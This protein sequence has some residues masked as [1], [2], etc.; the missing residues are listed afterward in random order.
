MKFVW[1]F[2]KLLIDSSLSF[3][4]INSTID[5]SNPFSTSLFPFSFSVVFA[6]IAG[7]GTDTTSVAKIEVTIPFFPFK[8]LLFLFY[9]TQD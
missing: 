6:A 2:N 3:L 9:T 8:Y 4:G 7:N 1:C 5:S